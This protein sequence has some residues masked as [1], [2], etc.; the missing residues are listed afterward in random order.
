MHMA[1]VKTLSLNGQHPRAA[2]TSEEDALVC[3]SSVH[4][5][6]RHKHDDRKKHLHDCGIVS[7]G[8]LCA[9]GYGGSSR[10]MTRKMAASSRTK[11]ETSGRRRRERRTSRRSGIPVVVGS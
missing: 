6:T 8:G 3:R 7:A 9:R 10:V 5:E 1:A 2:T 11:S 4:G